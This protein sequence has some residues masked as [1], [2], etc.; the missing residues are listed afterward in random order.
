M[1]R[2][3]IYIKFVLLL[4]L[5]GFLFGFTQQRNEQRKLKKIEVTFVDD[6]NPFVTLPTVNKLLIQNHEAI[7]GLPKDT[8]VLKEMESRL[9]A[10]DMVRDAQVYITVDGIL[11]ARIEQRNPLG[12]VSATP[13]YYVDA[14]GKPMPLSQV[15]AARVPLITGTS[16]KKFTEI[17]PLLVAIDTDPFMKNSV[18]GLHVQRNGKVLMRLRNYD[19]TVEFGRPEQIPQKFQYFKAFYKKAKED[20]RLTG[21]EQINLTFGNQVVAT[22]KMSDGTR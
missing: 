21:Y 7:T 3:W 2:S 10:H 6:N 11:G 18:V 15:Y 12:R 14:D 17:T 8:V 19:G 9:L 16:A 22:K 5:L 20:K 1:K 4:G 13:D